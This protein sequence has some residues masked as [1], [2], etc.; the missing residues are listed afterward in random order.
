[1]FATSAEPPGS[2]SWPRPGD[3]LVV[4]LSLDHADDVLAGLEPLLSRAE[5]GRAARLVPSASR[6]FVAGRGQLRRLLARIVGDP[7]ESLAIEAGPAGKPILGGRHAGR[8]HFNVSHS[9]DR[10]LVV[11]SADG[12]VGIDIECLAA[13]HTPAWADTIAGSILAADEFAAYRLLPAPRR[14]IAVLEAWVAKEAVLKATGQG[15]AAGVRHLALPHP[16]PRAALRPGAD[17]I[18]ATFAAVSGT[19]PG[20]WA[21]CLLDLDRDHRAALAC[22]RPACR[23]SLVPGVDA[24]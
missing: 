3:V 23:L 18:P 6:R 8:C 21:V 20:G 10:C 24:C 14:P 22:P 9:R 19:A 7:P 15:V 5:R 4:P 11:V 1:M 12:P 16:L 17:P 2:P 13:T